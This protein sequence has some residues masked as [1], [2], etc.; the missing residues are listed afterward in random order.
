[1]RR[2]VDTTAS[3]VDQ[4]EIAS[5]YSEPSVIKLKTDNSTNNILSVPKKVSTTPA[6]YTNGRARS[7][8]SRPHLK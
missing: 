4:Q 5:S 6:P 8:M 1:M 2:F 3:P 7:K